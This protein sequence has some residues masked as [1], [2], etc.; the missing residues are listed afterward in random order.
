MKEENTL[1]PLSN[2]WTAPTG[3]MKVRGW[4]TKENPISP[5]AKLTPE[6]VSVIKGLLKK[7]PLLPCTAIAKH[8]GMSKEA[9]QKIGRGKAWSNIRPTSDGVDELFDKILNL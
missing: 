5:T 8:F 9:I 3:W 1:D 6:Q 2:E 4:H 7:Y